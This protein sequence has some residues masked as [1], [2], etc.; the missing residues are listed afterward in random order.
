MGLRQK[1]SLELLETARNRAKQRANVAGQEASQAIRRRFAALGGVS[2]GAAIKQE[3]LARGRAQEI[4]ERAIEGIDIEEAR[5][6]QRQEEIKEQR[7]FASGEAL[8]AREF[9]AGQAEKQRGFL[10]GQSELGR[11]F[12]GE[13]G[14][15][16]RGFAAEQSELQRRFVAAESDEDRRQRNDRAGEQLQFARE[17]LAFE[18]DVAAFNKQIAAWEQG[19]PT[20]LFGSLLGPQ[21]STSSSGGGLGSIASVAA[22]PIAAIGGVFCFTAG[23]L[24]NMENGELKSIEDLELGDQTLLGGKVICHGRAI[25]GDEIYEYKSTVLEGNHMVFENGKWL[26]AKD[27]EEA[28]LIG[29]P[30]TVVY[31]VA[32]ENRLLFS[33]GF[34]SADVMENDDLEKLNNDHGRN[35]FLMGFLARREN[36]TNI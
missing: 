34:I 15:K 13:Q 1:G 18:K 22:A 14:E 20:D 4:G 21:F 5:E 16:Q 36:G 9:G 7:T 10:A 26:R 11:E 30:E 33:N 6:R 27:S 12:A 2:G 25:A 23:T 28:Y 32:T 29:F 8:K 17:Q 31:P 35:D 24:I 3:S 19:Q